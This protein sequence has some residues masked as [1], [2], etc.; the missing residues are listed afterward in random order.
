MNRFYKTYLLLLC[1]CITIPFYAQSFKYKNKKEYCGSYNTTYYINGSKQNSILPLIIDLNQYDGPV[2]V[3]ILIRDVTFGKDQYCRDVKKPKHNKNY[4][5]EFSKSVGSSLAPRGFK[6]LGPD[7]LQIE[8]SEKKNHTIPQ[9]KFEVD[10]N[11]IQDTIEGRIKIRFNIKR[12]NGNV[13]GRLDL[14]TLLY[15]ILPK[16]RALKKYESIAIDSS[17]TVKTVYSNRSKPKQIELKID[18]SSSER[19][20]ISRDDEAQQLWNLIIEAVRIDNKHKVQSLCY[21]YRTEIA[22]PTKNEEGVWFYS[23]KYADDYTD[24]QIITKEYYQ[25]FPQGKLYDK[26]VRLVGEVDLTDVKKKN[27]EYTFWRN[28]LQLNNK[29]AYKDYLK[30]YGN[31]KAKYAIEAK[32]KLEEFNIIEVKRLRQDSLFYISYEV[33]GLEGISPFVELLN[34]VDSITVE[35]IP[36]SNN[37]FIVSMK[38]ETSTRLIISVPNSPWKKDTIEVDVNSPPL[39]VEDF[40]V[41][42]VAGNIFIGKIYK[43]KPPYILE[44]INMDIGGSA[45]YYQQ[46]LEPQNNWQIVYDTLHTMQI[47]KYSYKV[48]IRDQMGVNNKVF[49]PFMLN[50]EGETDWW[51]YAIPFSIIGFTLAIISRWFFFS[52]K[53]EKTPLVEES[54]SLRSKP[55]ANESNK[56]TPLI[57]ESTLSKN[58]LIA[59]E[60]SNDIKSRIKVHGK[61]NPFTNGK[62]APLDMFLNNGEKYFEFSMNLLWEDASIDTV[63]FNEQC[64]KAINDFVFLKASTHRLPDGAMPEI[65]GFLI[66]KFIKENDLYNI[67]LDRFVDIESEDYGVYQI[68]FGPKAWSKLESEMDKFDPEIYE[69]IGWFHTHPGHGLFLS[70]PDQNIHNNFFKFPFQIAME[71]DNVKKNSSGSYDLGMFC[72][73]KNG[74]LNNA[75]DLIDNWIAWRALEEKLGDNI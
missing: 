15:K 8:S 10:N 46:F 67:T 39:K 4:L 44:I 36:K 23:I 75:E 21:K 47:G 71:I 20:I 72:V 52:T 56:K 5:L 55:I 65:G 24:K 25:K 37:G 35:I 42:S 1:L 38:P 59:N 51:F 13:E 66:G 62:A 30:K 41:D 12:V 57:E 32:L 74:I 14:R 54:T 58:K 2:T 48:N 6:K 3:G 28:T 7:I 73:K 68:S 26:I 16:N 27:A 64:I 70:L 9:I 31:E 69:L 49:G 19:T 22:Y 50:K 18:T 11:E 33:E 63:F 45:I 61:R 43:G 17:S 34:K 53:N 29:T 60:S 40:K